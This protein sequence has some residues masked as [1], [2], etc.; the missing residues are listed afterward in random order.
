[1]VRFKKYLKHIIG[2]KGI[3]YYRK[4]KYTI[5]NT[6]CSFFPMKDEIILE[7][8]PD[9][10]CNTYELFRYML[11]QNLNKRYRLV[12]LVSEPD[13]YI[14]QYGDNIEFINIYPRTCAERIKLYMRCNRAK[15]IVTTNRHVA[16]YKTSKKQLNIYIEH[17][18]PIK[19][20]R[21]DIEGLSCGYFISQAEFFTPYLVDELSIKKE[22]IINIG[23]PRN[24]QLFKDNSDVGLKLY[25][26]F[27]KFKKTIIWVP[28]FRKK[29]MTSRVDSSYDM[30]LGIPIVYSLEQLEKVNKLLSELN[31]LLIIKPHPAQDL[32]EL[33]KI[34][35]SNIRLL[36]NEQML[37]C[38]IQTNELLSQMDAM[39]TDYSG[40]YFDYLLLDRPVAIT[41]DDIKEYAEETGFV[42]ENPLEVLKGYYVYDVGAL[43][44]FINDIAVDR[45]DTLQER[46]EMK[47]QTNEYCDGFAA[48]RVYDFIMKKVR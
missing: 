32:G 47:K 48:K 31:I 34:D 45:D 5:F 37:A 19:Y 18:S 36:Y 1:M 39:I 44:S 42:F 46:M 25:A 35:E 16:K 29:I 17:G 13:K 20:A 7:S 21:P 33:Q 9:L 14:G 12:W 26:D 41:L 6:F 4:V 30:P 38:N 2:E 23:F 43:C 27:N 11:K 10:S 15:I 24:D 40:I 28:T 8:H 22:Q 3:L